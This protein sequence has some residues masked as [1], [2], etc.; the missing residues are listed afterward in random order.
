MQFSANKAN[1]AIILADVGPNLGA[2]NR[3]AL[4]GTDHVVVPLGADL[5]SLRGLRNLGPTLAHWRQEWE[6]RSNNW[7]E[8]DF[9]LPEGLMQPI[10]YVVQQH[11]VRLDRPVQ[12]YD[13]WINRMP[14]AYARSLLGNSTGPYPDTPTQDTD[15]LVATVK[16]YR[17]LVPMSQE[18][19][20][21]I[22][23]LDANDGAIGNHAVN[24]ADARTTF[25]NLANRIIEI[26]GL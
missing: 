8:P 5:F 17:S 25:Q 2:I 23:H 14:E 24:V 21:A 18:N 9:G 13:R 3:S 15:N 10:G 22:F 12:S 16:N 11:S 4:I 1:A 6:R 20:K 19:R 26:T 7:T